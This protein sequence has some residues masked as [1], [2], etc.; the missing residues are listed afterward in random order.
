[1]T[2]K[3]DD[4]YKTSLTRND[5][6]KNEDLKRESHPWAS[7]ALYNAHLLAPAFPSQRRVGK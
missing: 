3:K 6:R 2:R 4:E 5:I 1:M 7:P